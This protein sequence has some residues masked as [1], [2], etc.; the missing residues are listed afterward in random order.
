M[1]GLT[2]HISLATTKDLKAIYQIETLSYPDPWPREVFIMDYLF[3]SN[4]RYYVAKFLNKIIG[5]FGVWIEPEKLHIINIAVHPDYRRRGV[6]RKMIEFVIKLAKKKQKKE[7]YLEV[8]ETNIAGQELYK[9]LG[10]EFNGIIFDY[11]SDG[12]SGLIMRKVLNDHSWD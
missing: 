5:F 12:E 4:S 1:S 9:Q 8:R 3:N 6:G 11:Y 10:F 2:L 7:V